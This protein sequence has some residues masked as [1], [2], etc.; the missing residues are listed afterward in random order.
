MQGIGIKFKNVS[1]IWF[2]N[3]K[4]I[5]HF[6]EGQQVKKVIRVFKQTESNEQ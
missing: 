5:S 2:F 6:Q 3:E 1:G 4:Q